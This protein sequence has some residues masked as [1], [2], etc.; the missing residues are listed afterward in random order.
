MEL[1][2]LVMELVLKIFLF[3]WLREGDER[4]LFLAG[5]EG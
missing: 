5:W 3:L 4:Y 2:G 1:G